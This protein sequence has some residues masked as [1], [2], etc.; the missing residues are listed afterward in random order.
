MATNTGK[1]RVFLQGADGEFYEQKNPGMDQPG[2]DIFDVRIADLDHDG[3]GEI[4]FA[5]APIGT[6]GGGVWVYA[7][8]AAG[9]AA[10]KPAP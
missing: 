9:R 3:K 2:T 7:P 4:V 1:V 10:A 8:L 5:G 6:S